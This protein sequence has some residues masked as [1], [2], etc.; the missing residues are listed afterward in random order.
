MEQ[1]LVLVLLPVTTAA[2]L[3]GFFA[4]RASSPKELAL[5][6]SAHRVT[7]TEGN[8]AM[9]TY[10]VR[11]LIT[12][13]VVG[14]TVGLLLSWLF[15]DATGLDLAWTWW[16][17]VILGWVAGTAWAEAALRRPGGAPTAASLTPRRLAD[18][19]PLHLR[20]APWAVTGLVVVL[21]CGLMWDRSGDAGDGASWVAAV[22]AGIGA[23]ALATVAAWE[24]RRVVDR[25]QPV[26]TPDLVAV[27][28]AVRATVVH[29]VAGGVTAALL[30]VALALIQVLLDP[31]SLPYGIRGW[32]PL[33]LLVGA[34][35]AWR[36]SAHRAWS[37]R[38]ARPSPRVSV[39]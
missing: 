33:L 10:W 9:A 7:L 30:L 36:W 5:W 34:L 27:D 16:V 17:W 25:R 24:M 20:L 18:Y 38:R 37:V 14:G 13:R 8:R 2:V 3:V 4:R 28:D 12:L 29:H 15:S 35:V 26:A 23:I 39:P 6:A 21:A 1:V 31:R 22:A 11:L 19:L 32:A